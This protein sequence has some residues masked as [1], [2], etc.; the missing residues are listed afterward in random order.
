MLDTNIISHLLR[1]HP[2]VMNRL[3]SVPM[4][5]L[6]ISAITH[7]EMMY[8]LAK[9]PQAVKLQ[10]AVHELLLRVQILPFDEEAAQT[11]G[12]LKAQAEQSG[13]SLAALDMLIAA[14]AVAADA[15]LV[16]NDA[17][18]RHIQ[19]LKWEDWTEAV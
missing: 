12:R 10:R 5:A 2:Q 6:F 7:A 18:F 11:Y 14:H 17:A 1:Q 19:D 9:K 13:K 8:G 3:Q 4:S 16:S 15:V